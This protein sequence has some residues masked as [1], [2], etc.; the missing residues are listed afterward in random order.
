[1][2]RP[3]SG[4]ID[5]VILGVLQADAELAALMPEGV[6]FNLAAPGLTRF[7]LVGIDT[8]EDEG[9][10]G[11]RASESFRYVVQAVGLSRQV[12]LGTMKAAAARIDA[13]LE[14]DPLDAP[15]DYGSIDCVREERL[16]ESPLD[17][18]DKS[19]AW[20]H[21]GGYYRV[22]AYW[23]DPVAALASS[24]GSEHVD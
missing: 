24:G 10:F 7:V 23:P 6:W 15:P 11:S 19:L 12:D 17:E 2:A 16:A 21:F 4:A 13:L 3:D 8:A 14:G 1:M 9:L 20:H 18:L 5:R 22:T